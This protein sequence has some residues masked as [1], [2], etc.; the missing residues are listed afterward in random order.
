M[1]EHESFLQA[2]IANPADDAP[3]LI[4]ADWLEEHGNSNRAE[5][6]RIQCELAAMKPR[7]CQHMK[8][9]GHFLNSPVIM[10]GTE[11]GKCQW[12]LL[13]EREQALYRYQPGP[14]RYMQL[15]FDLS[16]LGSRA[17][18]MTFT[19][20]GPCIAGLK[21][22]ESANMAS[23][24]EC[25]FRRGFIAEVTLGCQDWLAHGPQLVKMTPL[26]KVTLSDK[27]ASA[28][29]ENVLAGETFPDGSTARTRWRFACFPGDYYA[30]ARSGHHLPMELFQCLPPESFDGGNTCFFDTSDAAQAALSNACLAW[31]KMPVSAKTA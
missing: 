31:A 11:C 3:R 28:L 26:E 2:I 25:V 29:S 4:Y 7:G 10:S 6:I 19:E 15:C 17:V 16:R 24:V 9:I 18:D 27:H 13:T 21:F 1:T 5:F 14:L 30:M 20:S 8:R 22:S 23:S 12:C